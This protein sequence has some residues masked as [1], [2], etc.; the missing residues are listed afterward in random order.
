[1][2]N[3]ETQIQE[4]LDELDSHP[5]VAKIRAEK[6]SERLAQ[7][8]KLAEELA[9]VAEAITAGWPEEQA[10][11]AALQTERRDLEEAARALGLKINSLTIKIQNARQALVRRRGLLQGELMDT[12][13]PEI[14]EAIDF[15]LEK[16]DYL[17][18]DERIDTSPGASA[19]NLA[20]WTKT[21]SSRS[22]YEAVCSALAYCRRAIE[23]LQYWKL[24]ADCPD[25][26]ALKAGIPDIQTF[27]EYS[28]ERPMPKMPVPEHTSRI[29]RLLGRAG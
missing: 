13:V 11:A 22:N 23:K 16:S 18:R 19:R 7:R 8:R 10:E 21:V 5:L 9:Q 3:N 26:E 27:T 15:F 24:L 28:G 17:R 2:K 1:M 12:A 20:G 4:R 6:E 14:E 25:I 29:R